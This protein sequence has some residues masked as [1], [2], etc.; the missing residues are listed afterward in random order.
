MLKNPLANAEDTGS[1]PG[2]GRSPGEGNI[3]HYTVLA[4]EIPWTEA[5]VGCSPW[6]AKE[7]STTW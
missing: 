6:V 4:W 5:L 7:E 1:V 2:L 3:T